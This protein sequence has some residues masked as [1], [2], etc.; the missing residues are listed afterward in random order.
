MSRRENRVR[1]MMGKRKHTLKRDVASRNLFASP[2]NRRNNINYRII[3][4]NMVR[5][6]F[7]NSNNNDA[8]K[9]N[10]NIT[11]TRRY[12]QRNINFLTRPVA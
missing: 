5:H 7:N 11:N 9:N 8:L 12:T 6:D 10:A 3:S 2:E 4:N 1:R